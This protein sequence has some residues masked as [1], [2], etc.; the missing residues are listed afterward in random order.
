MNYYGAIGDC[1]EHSFSCKKS[2]PR[3]E[4]KHQSPE[5]FLDIASYGLFC[6]FLQYIH[7][8]AF[9]VLVETLRFYHAQAE[10][11]S[12]TIKEY[13]LAHIK[14]NAKGVSWDSYVVHHLGSLLPC[15]DQNPSE[16]CPFLADSS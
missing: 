6:L 10:P 4:E 3:A 16:L 15:Q 11:K 14:K 1:S 12:L 5:I 8:T 9:H 13:L 2:Y 7:F